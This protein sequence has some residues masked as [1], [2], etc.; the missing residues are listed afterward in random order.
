MAVQ[1]STKVL[2][3]NDSTANW[4]QYGGALVLAQGEIA[5]ENCADGTNKIKIGDGTHTWSQ[6]PYLYAGAEVGYLHNGQFYKSSTYTELLIGY[7]N[8]LYVDLNS[9]KLYYYN[10]SAYVDTVPAASDSVP[11]VMKLYSTT[12]QNTDGTMTQK[13][14]TDELGTKVGAEYRAADELLIF[15]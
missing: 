3:R 6:L 1:I 13:G 4:T 10:G 15:S 5:I 2:L 7:T 11:G 14:I 12:G 9:H 8:R